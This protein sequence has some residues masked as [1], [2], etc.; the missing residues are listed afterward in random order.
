MIQN[1]KIPSPH[2]FVERF[3]KLPERYLNALL[4]LVILGIFVTFN[5][6]AFQSYFS[7]DDFSNLAIFEPWWSLVKALFTLALIPNFRPL[8]AMFYKAMGSL[9]GFHFG[10]YVAILQAF[11]ITTALMLS[12]SRGVLIRS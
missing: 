3:Q 5:K 6:A 12:T 1:L 10:A 8:G 9:A 7:D 4:L 11:H 2:A